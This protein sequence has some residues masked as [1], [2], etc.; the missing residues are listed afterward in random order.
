MYISYSKC[1]S[2]LFPVMQCQFLISVWQWLFYASIQSHCLW[3]LFEDT[4]C[5][6]NYSVTQLFLFCCPTCL[7][8]ILPNFHL[9]P[10]RLWFWCSF[11]PKQCCCFL[12]FLVVS[13]EFFVCIAMYTFI[14]EL[15]NFIMKY[16]LCM[17]CS[18]LNIF[19]RSLNL[20][21]VK[22]DLNQYHFLCKLSHLGILLVTSCLQYNSL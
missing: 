15:S 2:H 17:Q 11:I 8:F 16:F 18:W 20:Y 4:S 10:V 22:S 7:V 14:I 6:L 21:K 13:V 5:M 3:S 12:E 9:L 1:D 19:G